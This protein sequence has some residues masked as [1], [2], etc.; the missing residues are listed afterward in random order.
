M[1][2][3]CPWPNYMAEFLG[4]GRPVQGH[5]RYLQKL[6]KRHTL[7]NWKLVSEL[8]TAAMWS[9]PGQPTAR[10]NSK[11]VRVMLKSWDC[12]P[13][14]GAVSV[15]KTVNPAGQRNDTPPP[16]SLLLA[17]SQLAVPW[18][19]S[20]TPDMQGCSCCQFLPPPAGQLTHHLLLYPL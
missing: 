10:N 14:H 2:D 12:K 8:K 7:W 17:F 3:L 20:A 18:C 13:F 6:K 16:W 19:V 4:W 11:P 5:S 9:K 1:V 15:Q